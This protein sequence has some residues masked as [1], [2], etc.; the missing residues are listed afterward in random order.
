[1]SPPL[2]VGIISANWG[3]FAHLP[4]WRAVPGVEVVG[5]CTS[6]RETAEAA[7][8]KHGIPRAFWDAAAMAADSGIDIVDCGTRPAVRH[9]MVLAALRNGK[10]VY[11]AIPF[12]ADLDRARELRA[13][14]RASGKVGIVDAYSEW[15]PAHRQARELLD[16]GLLGQPFGGISTFNMPLFNQPD[17]RFPYNWFAEA[18]HGVSALRNLGSHALHLFIYLFGSIDEVV[19]HEGVLLPEWRFP[20]GKTLQAANTDFACLTLRFTSGMVLQFQ[21]SWCATLGAGWMLDAFGSRGRLPLQ[22][23]SFPTNR[24]TTLHAGAMGS[25]R[26][27]DRMQRIEMPEKF[28][29]SPDVRLDGDAPVP[30]S[31]GMALSMQRLVAAI[32]GNGMAAPDFEKAWQVERALA[33]AHRSAAERRWVKMDEIS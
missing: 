26:M 27:T 11:N 8:T 16:Q 24:D 25:D 14:W 32:H 18:G 9:A 4:A 13:A 21:V 23:P 2:R 20:D 28:W 15:L 10:H 19:A 3:A 12:A 5:I 7:A 6:R 1:M 22:A 17:P 29:R 31:Y 33:A 30:P